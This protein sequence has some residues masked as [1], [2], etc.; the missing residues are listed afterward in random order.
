MSSTVIAQGSAS[1]SINSQE[2]EARLVFIPSPGGDGWDV[3][4]VNKLAADSHLA[5][6]PDPK[7]LETFLHKAARTK[8]QDPMEMIFCKGIEPEEATYEKVSWAA[9][10]VPVDMIPL[11]ED[12]LANAGPPKI[13]R[14]T[15]ERIK[16]EKKV[17]KPGALPFM[18]AKEEI[19]VTW[20]KKETYEDVEVEG[21]VQEVMYAEK[22]TKLGTL[23]ASTPG[24]AGKSIFGRPI[25]PHMAA[26][27]SYFLGTGIARDSDELTAQVSGF[28]RIGKNWADMVP[29]S[30]PSWNISTGVDGVT[31]FF[32]FE[33][34][35]SR[36]APP[37][38]KE[39]LAAAIAKGAAKESLVSAGE[40]DEAIAEAVKT[41]EALEAFALFNAQEA[42]ARVDINPDKT[43]AI[44]YLR[45]GVAGALPLEMKAISQAIK[46]SGVQGFDTEQLKSTI[47]AFMEGKDLVLSDHVLAIG[48]P[49]TRGKDREIQIQAAL[50]SGEDQRAVL[51][52]L[53]VWNSRSVLRD[54][55]FDFQKATGLAFV[56]EGAVVACVSTACEGEEGKD[57]YGNVIPGLPGNDPYIK[58]F[59]G[60]ELHGSSIIASQGGLLLLE[61]SEKSFQGTVIKYRDAGIVVHIS[62][63]AMEA[64][65][66]L[67]REEGAGLSL[68]VENILKEMT[69]MGVKKGIDR[70][71]VEKACALARTRGCV[72][73]H[74][75]ARGEPPIA[76]GGSAVKWL[77]PISPAEPEDEDGVEAGVAGKIIQ[78]KAG[79]P[80]AEMSEPFAA[81]RHGYDVRGGE[82]PMGMATAQ[83]I[84][85]DNSIR[86]LRMGIESKIRGKRLVAARSGE[87]SFDNG[88]LK[89]SSVKTIQGDAGPDTG[90][91]NFSGEIQISGN[92][93]PGCV[94]MAGSH[95]I[96]DGIAEEA[97]IS[98]GGKAEVAL[99]FKGGGK[100]IIRARAGIETAFAERA[101][102]MAVGDIKLKRGS[103]LSTIKTNGKLIISAENGKLSGGVCQ[104]RHGIDTADMG[105]EK[106]LRTEIS[107]GQDY[108]IKDQI[109]VCEEEITKLRR[110]LSGTEEKIKTMLQKKQPL[111]DELK[112]EKVQQVKLLE[113]LNLKVF[114]LREKFEE[115]HES[116]IRVRGTVFPGVIIESHDRYYEVQQKRSRVIFYF[117]RKSGRIKEKPL[118]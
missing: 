25:P 90:N 51:D 88:E 8:T 6:Y 69:A 71:E 70:K 1:I 28:L 11:Q 97:L 92:V 35:D 38:G 37:T 84:T 15:V 100:G 85:H 111:N 86:A 57:I 65:V 31:L 42:V 36:F 2:T 102:I 13:I 110:T 4:A 77:V 101:S 98:A 78:V 18:P 59:R 107:F 29:L 103:I 67:L 114:N 82:I 30:K 55:E 60:L 45:K 112:K 3:A 93:L 96:V 104:A 109:G 47:L 81:G 27:V 117:D 68:S 63:N 91:I 53:N 99:G 54:G 89:I 73:G 17:K 64:R 32:H 66:D 24:K 40:L 16:H 113:Q 23:I 49:S 21:D 116:E 48:H 95:V 61:A 19:E 56:K 34:G 26:Y 14:T 12:A 7:G 10:P 50:F 106:G 5:A 108:L 87:L 115:H 44:L 80:I 94:L 46:E 33:P 39:V 52:R 75:L 58:L 83:T 43:R 105:S 118:G 62:N 72:S 76:H 74:I 20:E 22:G 9:L 41:G 79:A